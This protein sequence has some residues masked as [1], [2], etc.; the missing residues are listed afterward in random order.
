[1]IVKFP[2][3]FI[4]SN[5]FAVQRTVF[6]GGKNVQI[7]LGLCYFYSLQNFWNS[8]QQNSTK[9]SSSSL[10]RGRSIRNPLSLKVLLHHDNMA[11]WGLK[12]ALNS[13][14]LYQQACAWQMK[15][16]TRASRGLK[17]QR[18]DIQLR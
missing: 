6:L 7:W 16:C 3:C 11:L 4:L 14:P 18:H 8:F 13:T 1:M 12:K 2:C 10:H 15:N 17:T 9:D 5:N